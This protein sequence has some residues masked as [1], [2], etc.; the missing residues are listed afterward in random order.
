M[1]MKLED[2]SLKSWF[3]YLPTIYPWTSRNF[4]NL[5]FLKIEKW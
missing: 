1:D 2:L 5:S 4:F 3:Y